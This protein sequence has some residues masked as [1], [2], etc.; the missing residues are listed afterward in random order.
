M[1]AQGWLQTPNALSPA[2]ATTPY[3]PVAT[4]KPMPALLCASHKSKQVETLLFFMAFIQHRLYTVEE[5]DCVQIAERY[6]PER[7]SIFIQ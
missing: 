3:M 1:G 7:K 5:R 2:A 6:N 4:G